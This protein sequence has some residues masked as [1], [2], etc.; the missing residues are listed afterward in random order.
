MSRSFACSRAMAPGRWARCC[1]S[2]AASRE[3]VSRSTSCRPSPRRGSWIAPTPI[4]TSQ[5]SS[6]TTAR[7]PG[8]SARAHPSSARAV[9]RRSSIPT[10]EAPFCALTLN[11]PSRKS[12]RALEARIARECDRRG[13]LAT[14]GGFVRLSRPPL[15][16]DRARGRTNPP[17]RSDGLA[18]RLEPARPVRAVCR[19]GGIETKPL[20]LSSPFYGEES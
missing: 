11:E 3:A 2:S 17:A 9:I 13:L 6:P 18:R 7:S 12:Y 5:R 20:Q 15:R 10:A 4:A 8:R 1:V 19:A 16:A 14:K